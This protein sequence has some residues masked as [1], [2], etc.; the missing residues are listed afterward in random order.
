GRRDLHWLE[1]ECLG[2]HLDC[3][4]HPVGIDGAQTFLSDAIGDDRVLDHQFKASAFHFF[5]D[6]GLSFFNSSYRYPWVGDCR[7]ESFGSAFDHLLDR[8]WILRRKFGSCQDT[9]PVK[10]HPK[11]TEPHNGDVILSYAKAFE[12]G[13]V[14]DQRGGGVG[15]PLYEQGLAQLRRNIDPAHRRW[16]E[17]SSCGEKRKHGAGRGGRRRRH[18]LAGK[19]ARLGDIRLLQGEDEHGGDVVDLEHADE[20]WAGLPSIE[21]NHGADIGERHVVSP[22][23][24]LGDGV[25]RSITAVDLHIDPRALEVAAL[26]CQH[27]RRLLALDREIEHQFDVRS[28][29]ASRRGQ[30]AKNETCDEGVSKWRAHVWSP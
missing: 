10:G 14:G 4:L 25:R 13:E 3:L 23:R 5:V 15:S 28:L 26:V 24:D 29:C 16:I 2:Y 8:S 21:L 6:Q 18:P 19:I 12:P 17:T 22:A 20:R 30:R 7:L 11:I 9:V 1:I 27:E